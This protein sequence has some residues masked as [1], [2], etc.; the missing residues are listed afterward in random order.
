MTLGSYFFGKI[1][2]K[3]FRLFRFRSRRKVV[4]KVREVWRRKVRVLK[5]RFRRVRIRFILGVRLRIRLRVF[6]RV[7]LRVILRVRLRVRL[8][9]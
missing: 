3:F 7:I 8:R 2:F 5:V 4:K 9:V 6:L 1:V